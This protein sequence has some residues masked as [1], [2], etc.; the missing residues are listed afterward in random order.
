LIGPNIKRIRYASDIHL[1][2][3][4]LRKIIWKHDDKHFN[5]PVAGM[6][7]EMLIL[8]G[9]TIPMGYL[10]GWRNDERA[11]SMKKMFQKFCEM[12][13][14]FAQVV[15]IPGNH[16]Y[17]GGYFCDGVN[18]YNEFFEKHGFTNFRAYN[19]ECL[20]IGKNTTLILAT[21]W[22]DCNKD[23]PLTHQVLLQGMSDYRQIRKY[24][25][26]DK[27]L[28]T[29]DTVRE[30]HFSRQYIYH[31]ARE[32][33]NRNIVVATHHIPT[34]AVVPEI[35]KHDIHFNGGYYNDM[36]EEIMNLPNISHWIHGHNHFNSNYMIGEKCRLVSNQ[37]GYP[38]SPWT[39]DRC[40]PYEEFDFS[41]FFTV[42]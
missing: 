30:H 31:I 38:P 6:H 1:E 23:S 27:L 15:L 34:W 39:K 26:D 25:D 13:S 14:D 8:A 24:H 12:L 18:P 11:R 33:S 42:D 19:N 5:A 28:R 40:E 2:F 21:L 35:F 3:S 36:E 16:E 17:Y 10:Y 7:E 29:E 20:H 22:T 32:C 9:D 41:R 4:N 37:R